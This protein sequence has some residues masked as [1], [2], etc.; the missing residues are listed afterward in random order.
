MYLPASLATLFTLSLLALSASAQ[1]T[2]A[3]ANPPAP[4]AELP[5]IHGTILSADGTACARHPCRVGESQHR[6]AGIVDLH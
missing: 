2:Q 3:F 4:N 6:S 5:A 1:I